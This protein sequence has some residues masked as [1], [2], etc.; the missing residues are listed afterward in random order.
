MNI[1]KGI[2]RF[3]V[4]TLISVSLLACK[5]NSKTNKGEQAEGTPKQEEAAQLDTSIYGNYVD[6][7]YKDRNQGYDWI[8]V[9]VEK[10]E[11]E[12]IFV[13]IRSRAD[14]KSPTCTYDT[15]A[16]KKDENLYESIFDGKPIRFLFAKG[17]ITISGETPENSNVLYYF[18]SGGASIAG[19]YQKIDTEL[20]QNQVDLTK[21]TKVLNLQSVGFNVS[22]IEKDGKNTLTIFT[23]GLEEREYNET[24][25]INNEEVVDA[26][27]EDLNSDGSPELFVFTQSSAKQKYGYVYAFSV[28]NKKSMSEVYFQPT[29]ENKSINNGYRGNDTF[30]LI[31]NR[32]GQRFPIYKEG[33]A[34]SNPTGGTRQ[35]TYKLVEGEALRQ[36]EVDKVSEY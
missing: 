27:V 24:L 2:I 7:S 19:T 16:Y 20:D 32:L 15:K 14:K 25:N 13:S 35:I 31:E 22:S 17:T 33:D 11:E 29:S 21:F 8:G 1:N 30:T 12:S 3:V 6:S 26:A 9:I 4:I 5:N 18:C 10:L 36:L 28:N 34:D 23:F